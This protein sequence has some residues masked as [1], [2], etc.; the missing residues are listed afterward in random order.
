MGEGRGRD[1]R[2]KRRRKRGKGR[3]GGLGRVG[4]MGKRE[5]EEDKLAWKR[6]RDGK[7]SKHGRGKREGY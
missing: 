7:G 2:R 5:L 1:V 4:R 3:R 6:L